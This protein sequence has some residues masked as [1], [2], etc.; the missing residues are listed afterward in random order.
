MPHVDLGEGGRE[1]GGERSGA[2]TI[3]GRCVIEEAEGDDEGRK[4]RAKFE[5]EI[6]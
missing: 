3:K 6:L 2:Q 4:R 1:G 5:K